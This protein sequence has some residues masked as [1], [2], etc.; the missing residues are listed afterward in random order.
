MDIQ[1]RW[2]GLP[3]I[4]ASCQESKLTAVS[5][6]AN[7]CKVTIV[8]KALNEAQHIV[9]AVESALKA[10]ASVGGEVV[11]AD[12]CSTDR[13]VELASAFPVR[14]VQL[15][16]AKERCCGIGPQLG[17]QHSHGEYVYILD[18]DMQM[19][20]GFLPQAIAYMDGHPD[21]GGVG[22]RV[23]EMNTSS[24]EYRR[25]TENA[26]D[27]MHEGQ[28][29]RLDMGGLYRRTAIDQAGY[30][31]D[32]NLHSYEELDLALRLR[33]HGWKLWR[34]GV[35]AVRHH[36]HDSPPYALLKRR[37][38]T[39][40]ICGLGELLRASWSNPRFPL[41]WAA[42]H[43]LRLYA[44]VMLWMLLLL[45]ILVWPMDAAGKAYAFLAVF[46]FPVAMATWRKR[47]VYK[48]VYS[49]VSWIV[50]TFGLIRGL[51][52]RREP[53]TMRIDSILVADQIR[54]TGPNR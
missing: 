28:V 36:G 47:S 11:L 9:A 5:P 1:P 3:G 48:A 22:G 20:D 32:R 10:V 18:G 8:I 30:F 6:Q 54:S 49:V 19:I 15:K 44:A 4:Q 38:A 46:L 21:I 50:N 23:V 29:D 27:H 31:S 17:Y 51:S 13:T 34:I 37:W 43:E 33:S 41:L 26:A 12:S 52:H 14:I 25:R 45:L 42:A 35:D 40:Y 16:H 53:A 7:S 2:S 24:L 39:G